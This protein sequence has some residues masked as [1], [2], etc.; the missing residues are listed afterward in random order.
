MFDEAVNEGIHYGATERSV[1]TYGKD[2]Y[3]LKKQT[4]GSVHSLKRSTIEI[5]GQIIL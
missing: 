2:I 3:F 4:L 5:T 1:K